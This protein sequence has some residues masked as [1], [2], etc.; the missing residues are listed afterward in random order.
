LLRR[1]GRTPAER[2]DLLA[3]TGLA[4]VA[5]VAAGFEAL[6]AFAANLTRIHAPTW[7]IDAAAARSAPIQGALDVAI[8]SAAR[9]IDG[10]PSIARDV[11]RMIAAAL[12]RRALSLL[13]GG[14]LGR[15]AIAE[16]LGYADP[17]SFSRACRLW[18]GTTPPTQRFGATSAKI[19]PCGSSAWTIHCPPGTSIGPLTI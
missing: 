10:A 12:P 4:E 2:A 5:A 18:F 8:R 11:E 19:A 13:G 3:G 14:A 16:V 7:P 17:T 9:R 15:A 1:F 6:L